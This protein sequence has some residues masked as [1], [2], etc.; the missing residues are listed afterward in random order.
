MSSPLSVTE[1]EHGGIEAS[2]GTEDEE[3]A[4]I[5][6]CVVDRRRNVGDANTAIRA[7]VNIDLVVASTWNELGR[8]SRR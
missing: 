2:K 4:T 7:G 5:C 6:G 3:H 8:S 1:S